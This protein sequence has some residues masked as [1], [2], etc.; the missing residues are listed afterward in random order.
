MTGAD[1]LAAWLAENSSGLSRSAGQHQFFNEGWRC[2]LEGV[3]P[4]GRVDGYG[5]TPDAAMRAAVEAARK[6]KS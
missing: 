6:E 5:P 1:M 4:I 3:D 2:V